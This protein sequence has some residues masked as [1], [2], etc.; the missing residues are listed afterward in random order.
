[1]FVSDL[2]S[3]VLS[4]DVEQVTEILTDHSVDVNHPDCF[5]ISVSSYVT[6]VTDVDKRIVEMVRSH[7]SF[8]GTLEHS[9]NSNDV[10]PRRKGFV[11][12]FS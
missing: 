9:N 6:N 12:I 11:R 3:A 2:C 5:G 8:R 10:S 4:N 1:M 7:R